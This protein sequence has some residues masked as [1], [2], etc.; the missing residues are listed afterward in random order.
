MKE[1]CLLCWAGT[2][3]PCPLSLKCVQPGGDRLENSV[4]AICLLGVSQGRQGV[5]FQS[6]PSGSF[7]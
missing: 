1:T 7:L 3:H 4:H 2:C 6:S 5:S